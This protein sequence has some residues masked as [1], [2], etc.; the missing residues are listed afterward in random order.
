[1]RRRP[2]P[3]LPP[4]RRS[5]TAGSGPRE[6]GPT[7]P[8]KYVQWFPRS[9]EYHDRPHFDR[10]V[11]SAGDARGPRNG[12]VEILAFKQVITGHLLFGLGERTVAGDGF[13]VAPAP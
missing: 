9:T 7:P 6:C 8:G 1:M 11:R 5:R 13:G 2:A 12:F 10:S 3:L 4:D